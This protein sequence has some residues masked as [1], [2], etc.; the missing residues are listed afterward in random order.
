MKIAF[1]KAWG[2][3]A[4]HVDHLISIATAGKY[5]HTELVFSDGLSFSISGRSG[6]A[7]F[8]NIK[9]TEEKWFLMDI[10]ISPKEEKLLR[11]QAEKKVARKI[12][13]DYPGAFTCGVLPFCIHRKNKLF[14]SESSVIILRKSKNYSFLD[15]GCKYSPMR[16]YRELTKQKAK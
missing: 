13:Y 11:K 14:C 5:S 8:A 2:P 1:Y 7:R 6:G 4:S 9:Y 12:Q 15:E 16:L 10:D 3:D